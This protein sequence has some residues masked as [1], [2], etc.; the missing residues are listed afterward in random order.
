MPP[1]ALPISTRRYIRKLSDAIIKKSKTPITNAPKT[2]FPWGVVESIQAGPPQ[3]LTLYLSGAPTTIAGVRYLA[4]Y[5]PTEGDTVLCRHYGTD[6]IVLGGTAG[7]VLGLP[8]MMPTY[9]IY[10]LVY[11]DTWPGFY[12]PVRAGTKVTLV[13]VIGI[14]QTGTIDV[15]V[16]RTPFG[17]SPSG[18]GGLTAV[19]LSTTSTGR[20][21]PTSPLAVADLDYFDIVTSSGASA[22]QNL[23]LT[24]QFT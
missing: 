9:A 3:T 18:I 19:A 2:D 14:M 7:A 23:S 11:N 22:P 12:V 6:L 21:N 20:V 8:P 5:A 15:E 1:D 16:R 24:L 13:A 4:S 17:G 10:G